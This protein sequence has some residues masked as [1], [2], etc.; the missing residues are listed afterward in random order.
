MAPAPRL[1]NMLPPLAEQSRRFYVLRHGETD[2][3]LLGKLQGGGFDIPLTEN[4]RKQA[5]AV[6][7]ELHDIP[8]GVVAS[9]PLSRARETVEILLKR[10]LNKAGRHV[11]DPGF[12]EMSFGEFE[13]IKSRDPNLDPKIKKTL[14]KVTKKIQKKQKLQSESDEPCSNFCMTSPKKN[15]WQLS[16]TAVQTKFL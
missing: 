16:L 3:N 13:G 7:E 15:M 5:M 1:S 4:G 2:W 9:S 12:A 8:I 14:S 10:H 6:A 11:V